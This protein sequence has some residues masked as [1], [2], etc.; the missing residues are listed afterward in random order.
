MQVLRAVRQ[1]VPYLHR[2]QRCCCQDPVSPGADVA[3]GHVLGLMLMATATS[4]ASCS[5]PCLLHILHGMHQGG[6]VAGNFEYGPVGSIDAEQR[7]S[8]LSVRS[9][10][11][12]ARCSG[13]NLHPRR[14]G[15]SYI[16]LS[17]LLKFVLLSFRKHNLSGTHTHK[18]IENQIDC[19]VWLPASR[20]SGRMVF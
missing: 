20:T 13:C 11:M 5:C 6:Q 2:R 8:P 15:K 19:C 12:V 16:P 18:P 9:S 7:K 10:R 1:L 17:V 3:D 4:L 14:N